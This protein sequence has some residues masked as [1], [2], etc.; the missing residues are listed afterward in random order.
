MDSLFHLSVIFFFEVSSFVVGGS[1]Y[2]AVASLLL[3]FLPFFEFPARTLRP[4]LFTVRKTICPP[5]LL[6]RG[7]LIL[8]V[9]RLQRSLLSLVPSTLLGGIRS[10]CFFWF[11]FLG[12]IF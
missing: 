5:L 3:I 10:F 7:S 4:Y 12:F 6:S 2:V 8:F 1:S 9:C 11:Y